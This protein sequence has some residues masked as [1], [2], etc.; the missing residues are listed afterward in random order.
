[1]T[2]KPSKE[3]AN[4]HHFS[5]SVGAATALKSQAFDRSVP[6]IKDPTPPGKNTQSPSIFSSKCNNFNELPK[7]TDNS[8]VNRTASKTPKLPCFPLKSS[9]IAPFMSKKRGPFAASPS[10]FPHFPGPRSLVPGPWPPFP[11]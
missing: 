4:S 7:H 11:G 6:P 2:A 5:R 8:S 3:N 10:H 1:M 9:N